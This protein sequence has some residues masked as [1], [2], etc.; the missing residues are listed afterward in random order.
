V[1]LPA[2]EE[3]DEPSSN[4]QKGQEELSRDREKQREHE[5]GRY[6]SLD[7]RTGTLYHA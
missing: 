6:D 4:G 5:C 2:R 7:E 3:K 1:N